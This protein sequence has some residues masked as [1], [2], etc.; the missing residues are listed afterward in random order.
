MRYLG[1]PSR[2][3]NKRGFPPNSPGPRQGIQHDTPSVRSQYKKKCSVPKNEMKGFWLRCQR[4]L[5]QRALPARGFDSEIIIGKLGRHTAPGSAV[6]KADLHEKGLV[7]FLDRV[8]LFSQDG[9]KGIHTHW[10]ALIFLDNRKQQPAIHF[11]ET[12]LVH[13]QHLQSGS[14]RWQIDYARAAHLRV[15]AYPAQQPIGNSRRSPRPAGYL[16]GAGVIDANA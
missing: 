12:V 15:I 7:N 5:E 11:I 16:G 3:E 1:T 2:T 10:P 6:E 9:S 8:G 13:F 14:S 4:H